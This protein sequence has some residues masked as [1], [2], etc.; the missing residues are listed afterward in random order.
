MGIDFAPALAGKTLTLTSGELDITK[1]VGIIGSSEAISGNNSRRVRV[2]QHAVPSLQT[3]K[4]PSFL[5]MV[6]ATRGGTALISTETRLRLEPVGHLPEAI[7][8]SRTRSVRAPGEVFVCTSR[9]G[10][11]PAD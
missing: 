3:P 2:R 10:R 7:T 4:T 5:L 8:P 9:P 11:A 1:S 6:C